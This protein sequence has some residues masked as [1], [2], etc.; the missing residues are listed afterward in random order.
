MTKQPS[1][2]CIGLSGGIAC[3]KSA[4]TKILA[5]RGL[6]VIDAD[7][8]ARQ[9]VALG[10]S[11]L[12]EIVEAFGSRVLQS[13]GSLDR[14]ELGKIV[15]SSPGQKRRLDLILHPRIWTILFAQIEA[16][17]Q[18][19]V[20]AVADI[21]LLFENQR[22]SCFSETWAIVC[23]EAVQI[24]R[25]CL[26]NGLNPDQALLRVRSQ[27]PNSEKSQLATRVIDNDGSLEQLESLVE[28][29]L[30]AWRLSEGRGPE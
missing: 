7:V 16:A 29:A 4:V 19:K 2:Y 15:F 17:E 21:P 11:G 18:E 3:G 6:R 12:R 28:Y 24:E 10:S 13:D 9:V 5:E 20:E 22:E 14:A 25:L 26:R 23:S 27:M 1:T 8:V 30:Q